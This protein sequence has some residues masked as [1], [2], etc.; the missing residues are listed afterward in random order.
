MATREH[1]AASTQAW[2]AERADEMAGLLIR[3]VACETENPPGAH[4]AECAGI[5]RAAMADLGLAPEILEAEPAGTVEAPRVVR[6]ASGAAN[7]AQDAAARAKL[8]YFHGHFDVVPA[9]HRSQFTAHR[10][11]GTITG[12]GTAD[13]KG[14]IVSMLYGAAAARD[15]GL[16]GD[17]RIVIHLVCDEETGSTIGSGYLA[18]HGLIDPA[19][20]A[21]LTAEQSGG[22][23]WPAAKGAISLRVEVR[24]RPAHV[25]QAMHGV[26]SFLHMLKVATP[27][28][29]YAGQL[30][31]RHTRH[32]VGDGQAVGSTV[33]LGGRSGGGSNFNVVPGRT[34]F[35]VDG[36]FNPEEDLEAELA[37]LTGTINAA[38]ADA[39][40][41]VAIEVTQFAPAADTPPGGHAARI[42]GE[43][44]A[45][46]TGA[47][48]RFE[49]CPGCLDTRWYAQ[50]GIPAFGF[51]PGRFDVSHGPDEYVAEAELGRT[52][53]VYALFAGRMLG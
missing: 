38:A 12:R 48:A 36:R 33:V 49:L 41:D 13:M 18:D 4:L 47:P 3:L 44:V 5:L 51:G 11:G 43:C 22:V 24:G 27:L 40:A 30:S 53:A 10:A 19:A 21:M 7:H 8:V 50:R 25:G 6:G 37:R 16:L 32:P 28:E 15:L 23:I 9:Q 35:T 17:G 29:A 31:R 26:N 20:L 39:G 52:A 42:L 1:H 46:V 34:W 45:D 14:G 2:I